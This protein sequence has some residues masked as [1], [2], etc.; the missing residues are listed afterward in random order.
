MN[1]EQRFCEL[2]T[3]SRM[4]WSARP[5]WDRRPI[6][7]QRRNRH[8]DLG[9]ARHHRSH[10]GGRCSTRDRTNALARTKSLVGVAQTKRE[11]L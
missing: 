9:M 3:Y 8:A 10:D 5:V 6:G 11:A 1:D 7:R 2:P 4:A